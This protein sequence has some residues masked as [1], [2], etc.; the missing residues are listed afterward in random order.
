MEATKEDIGKRAMF[1][2]TAC[3]WMPRNETRII[4]DVTEDGGVLVTHNGWQKCFKVKPHEIHE[5][6]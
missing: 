1:R 6:I 3:N 4:H 5:I 2:L